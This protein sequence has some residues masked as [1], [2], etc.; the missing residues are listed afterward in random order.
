[1]LRLPS[2][3]G[4]SPSRDLEESSSRCVGEKPRQGR[5]RVL[6]GIDCLL[7][8]ILSQAI[9]HINMDLRLLPAKSE[10]RD[11]IVKLAVWHGNRK[12]VACIRTVKSLI[13]NMITGVTKGFRYKIKAVYAHFPINVIVNDG[14]KS[15]EIRNFLGEKV[16]TQIRDTRWSEASEGGRTRRL[17]Q[18]KTGELG[19]PKHASAN[20]G[21]H[22]PLESGPI[23]E[24]T[25]RV[26]LPSLNRP[27]VLCIT[28]ACSDF[29]FTISHSSHAKCQC[30]RASPS[31]KPSQQ[32]T[33][34]GSRATTSRR[35]HRVQRICTPL[36]LY[37]TRISENSWMVSTSQRRQMSFRTSKFPIIR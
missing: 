27:S 20:G 21:A 34:T 6:I 35:S 7:I 36:A 29:F 26:G 30:S 8:P 11:S 32:R 4:S 23:T 1:M 13:E 16:S 12:H 10:G 3:A 9:K 17:D 19:P 22:S 18:G 31:P 5:E 2:R 37:A 25:A 14:G 33:S 24:C 15:V 28:S